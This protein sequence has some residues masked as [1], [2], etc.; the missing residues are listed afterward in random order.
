MKERE[1]IKKACLKLEQ[2]YG[3]QKKV[4]EALN[5][6]EPWYNSIRNGK[7]KT[8]EKTIKLME[9]MGV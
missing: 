5:L 3:T 7:K 8:A 1:R 4:A 6:S 2:K 9:L